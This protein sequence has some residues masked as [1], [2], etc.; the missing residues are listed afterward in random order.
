M[1]LRNNIFWL[2]LPFSSK[3][4]LHFW[5]KFA[6]KIEIWYEPKSEAVEIFMW[7][8]STFWWNFCLKC[9]WRKIV[10]SDILCEIIPKRPYSSEKAKELILAGGEICKIALGWNPIGILNLSA[11]TNKA[12]WPFQVKPSFSVTRSD[13]MTGTSASSE[14]SEA[15][16]NKMTWKW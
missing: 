5:S 8:M 2:Q 9:L 10:L 3:F 14:A 11:L 15:N 12:W 13:L 16:W 6:S 4:I 7:K 1:Y